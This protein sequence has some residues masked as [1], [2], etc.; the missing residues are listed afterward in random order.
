MVEDLLKGKFYGDLS[1]Q[2]VDEK[3]YK[4]ILVTDMCSQNFPINSLLLKKKKCM[5]FE[6]ILVVADTHTSVCVNS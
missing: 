3:M 5:F 1:L 6:D 2:G 4:G